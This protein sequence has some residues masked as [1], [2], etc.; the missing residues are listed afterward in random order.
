MT[1]EHFFH[2]NFSLLDKLLDIGPFRIGGDGTTIFNSE[3]YLSEPF[4]CKLGPSMRF[5]YDFA[6]PEKFEFVLPTGQSGHFFSD[7]YDDMTS[8]WLKGDY[9]SIN[10]NVDTIKSKNYKLLRLIPASN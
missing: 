2:G 9:I 7:H 6:Y 4:D 5:I 1:F 3:Y 8:L 10:T